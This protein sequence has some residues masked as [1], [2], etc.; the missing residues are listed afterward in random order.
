MSKTTVGEIVYKVA[1][2]SKDFITGVNKTEKQAKSGFDRVK[3]ISST[4]FRAVEVAVAGATTAV[5]GFAKSAIDTGKDFDSSM[6]QVAATLGLTTNDIENNVNGAGDTFD[7]LRQKAAEM[8]AATVF[9]ASQ[10]ADGLNILAMSG[11][12]ATQSMSMIEDVL[13]LAAAGSMEMADAAGYVSGT[14]KGFND[15]TKTSAYYADLMTKGATLANT[16]V[17]E[18]GEAMSSGA[19]GAAAYGQSADSMTISLLRL[20]EQGE[21]GSA[22]GTALAAAMK[23]LYTPTDQAKK[24]LDSLGVAAYNSDGSARDFNEVVNDLSSALSNMSDEEAAAYKQTIFGIQGLDAFNKMTVTGVKKQKEWAAALAG[25]TGE[26][27][28]QYDTMTDNLEG[29]IAIWNSAL[30]GF[31]VALSDQMMPTIREFVQL[32]SDG[33]GKITEAF[34]QNGIDGAIEAVSEVLEGMLEK[35]SSIIPEVIKVVKAVIDAVIQVLPQLIMDII[36][37][38]FD[39]LLEALLSLIDY[40]PEILQAL[41]TVAFA[42]VDSLL[43]RLPEILATIVSA[44]M[45]FVEVLTR[46][47]NINAVIKAALQLLV[48]IVDAIPAVIVAIV[49]ALPDIISNIIAFL[50]DPS[51]IMLIIEAAVQLFMGV[52]KAVP[53]ILG[54][55][56]QAFGELFSKLWEKVT[57][58]FSNFAQNIGET[59]SGIFKEVING[60]LEFIEGF[61][62]APIRLING[63]LGLINGAFGWLGVNIGDIE[64]VH[65][66]RLA[67]GGIVPA[68]AGGQLILAGEGGEDEWVVP[69]SKMASL[70]E[71]LNDGLNAGG[72]T[73][74][75]VFNGVL[76]TPDEMRELAV[77]FHDKYEEVKKAR[78]L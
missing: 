55:L 65:L 68:T 19:A 53:Q 9:T 32:G 17:A 5:V 67:T 10:A 29:D 43:E 7:A 59:I 13:H 56:C 70:I 23:N 18:L 46:P 34:Q 74:N 26:A 27:S 30:D 3:S 25:S 35:I 48:A 63:F 76:G 45:G 51:T 39:A 62:N 20:A 36:P 44:I 33:M 16:S 49:E 41:L 66:P 71:K 15:A 11:Y 2:D 21:A 37:P 77:V 58:I 4:A 61:I 28:K 60:V 1:L 31:K 75:F 52:V 64:L 50:V 72:E 14:M 69:E 54:A 12:D 40:L 8:G 42:V 22:A 24:A 73:L 78:M 47:E 57:Q 6:S 38:L